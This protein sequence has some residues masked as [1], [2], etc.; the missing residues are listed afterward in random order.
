MDIERKNLEIL[1]REIPYDHINL[2]HILNGRQNTYDHVDKSMYLEYARRIFPYCSEDERINNYL[3]LCEEM[4]ECSEKNLNIFSFI[5]NISSKML[6]LQSG[7]IQCRLNEMLRWREISFQLGQEFF[8]CAF[9]AGENLRKGNQTKF[10][11][12]QPIISSDD[13]RLNNILKREIAENHFHLN[14]STKIFELNWI[15][16]M[17]H[18]E[19]RGKEFKR[20]DIILQH[21]Y[22]NEAEKKSFYEMCQEAALYRGYLFSVI[23]EN[24]FL[25][26]QMKKIIVAI[27]KKM[28][29]LWEKL[30]EIQDLICLTGS[31]Y[32]A[33]NEHGDMLDYALLKSNYDCNNNSCRLL[34]GERWLLYESYQNCLKSGNTGFS[35]FDKNIF[36]R[37]LV[38]RTFFRSEMIQVN[39]M[40]GFSNFDQY[41]L[42]KEYFIEGK[43]AYENE[44]V[45]LAVNASFEKQNICSLEARICPYIR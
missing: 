36:Y 20:F 25:I 23:C 6:T 32:G 21:D 43:R 35:D 34:A 33:V 7:E 27:E 31:I 19:N 2:I 26:E 41:Q 22:V 39:K 18:I 38:L 30:S 40:V 4:Q 37:Y 44:L 13:V 14:G 16:L 8:T 24:Q 28:V 42:R 15:C 1:F 11:A 3:L 29:F 45:R 10:F 9:L 17:N 12:W 5:Y